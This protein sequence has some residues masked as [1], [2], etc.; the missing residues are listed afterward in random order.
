MWKTAFASLRAHKRRLLGTCSAVLLGIAFLSGTLMLGDSVRAGFGE[1]FEEANAGTDA[2]VRSS[3]ELES[4]GESEVGMLDVALVDEV[5]A[6]DGVATAVPMIERGGQMVGADGDPIGG[7]GPPTLAGNW[8]DDP[9][10]NPY[11]IVE[12]R[13]PE[14]GHEVVIDKESA[15]T[16]DLHVGDTATVR[17]PAPVEVTVVG[18]ATAGSADSFG[19]TTF[20][21]FTLEAAQELLAPDPGQVTPSD[22]PAATPSGL[23][24][25]AAESITGILVAADDGVAQSELVERLLPLLPEDA[26]AITGEALTEEQKEQIET[27]FLG[28]LQNFLLVFAGIALVV[29]A[30]SIYNTFSIVVAQR[31]RESALLRALGASRRQILGSV[32]VEAVVV[33]LVASGLG[34]VAGI[35]LAAGLSGLMSAIGFDLPSSSRVLGSDT[36]TLSMIVG[37]VVTVLASLAPAVKASRV[38]PLAALRDVAVDRAGHQRWRALAGAVVTGAGVAMTIAGATAAGSLPLTGLGALAVVVGVVMFG[39][40]AAGPVS[41]L[42]GAPIARLRGMS[43]RLARRNAMRNPRRTANTASALMVGVAVVSMFTVVAASLKAYV[44][45]TV[46]DA[47]DA[48]LVLVSDDFSAVG[49][50]PALSDEISALPEVEIATGFSDALLRVDGEDSFAT[51]ANGAELAQVMDVGVTQGTLEDLGDG[52]VALSTNYAEDHGWSMGSKVPVSFADGTQQELTVAAIYDDAALMG[53][54]LISDETWAAHAVQE[55]DFAISIALAEGVGL[56]EGEQAVQAVADRYF[57]PDVQTKEEYVDAVASQVD[58]L[59][60]VIYVMLLLAIIIALMGIANT[61]SLSIHE[62]TRELG[63][64]RAVG[65]SRR[66]LRSMVRGESLIVATF[67][68]VGGIGLG[69]FLGWALLKALSSSEDDLDVFAVPVGQL[70]IVLA[71]GATVGLLAALR[72]A[73]RAAKLDVLAA[74]A[75]D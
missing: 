14:S 43:G 33:G 64:L 11:E 27:D 61:L 48:D 50:S 12:G 73:R 24:G 38:L 53:S 16:G 23:G 60:A 51:A 19:G 15:D 75:S 6:V 58:Q 21:G 65:Q 49:L 1:L 52:T 72:P 5:A 25:S 32:V 4:D 56:A 9:E 45:Q 59:L 34:L 37:L 69:T 36:V 70:L 20:A 74:I 71:L 28:F 46:D 44:D 57:A 63:L 62:R 68:A 3:T 30:F 40:V 31:T 47:F 67:G 22:H 39:P 10:L 13:A 54:V 66:Q 26:E 17:I 2:L 42:L 55:S 29:A 41:G 35:G 7:G 8:I 18:I